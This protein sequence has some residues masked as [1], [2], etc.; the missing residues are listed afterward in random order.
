[1]EQTL[2]LRLCDR[3]LGRRLVGAQGE[4]AQVAA[5]AAVRAGT[6]RPDSP[7][8]PAGDAL[9]AVVQREPVPPSACVVCEGAFADAS[10]WLEAAL[11]AAAPYAFSTF[12]V[13]TAFPA[14]CEEAERDAAAA[15]GQEAVGETMRTEAN[16][17]LAQEIAAATGAT[18]VPEGR[19]DLVIQ[20]DTRFWTAAAE[21]NS[22][23][24]AGRYTKHRRD[25]PQTHWPCKRCQGL[26]CHECERA[27]VLYGSSVEDVIGQAALPLFDA[28]S[29]SFHGA[30]RED[31]DALM[32]GT[33]RPFV[34]ELKDPTRRNA[35]PVA[36]QGLEAKIG[37]S[38]PQEGVGVI[39]LRMTDKEE[40][41]RIKE[42]DYEKEYLAHCETE[43][44]IT[45]ETV[46]RAAASL[47]GVSLE[48]RTPERVS[49][50]R[51]DK[52]RRRTVHEIRLE[53]FEDAHHFLL[54]VRA[55]S[56][57]YIKEMV[58]SDDGRT[59]PSLSEALG[60]PTR[61]A[62]LDVLA[63]LDGPDGLATD[64]P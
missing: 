20:V 61:V 50:R 59:T 62:F 48:Q 43:A 19:P 58:S 11:E 40:V 7:L 44:P 17:W 2:A 56:G 22:V 29:Y 54:R 63:I 39:G 47:E 10:R 60:V 16:R 30:G 33:G 8:A 3:C 35:D 55:E 51:A 27:G 52:V 13:G 41:A 37:A 34:L 64:T 32:I 45:K 46:R 23:Y 6:A 36:L 31:I 5:A 14:P 49:H 15:L 18:T 53:R 9:Q 25:I 57:T 1:M 26:G 21:A 28:A 24:L 42:A 12:Q 38:K 4:P